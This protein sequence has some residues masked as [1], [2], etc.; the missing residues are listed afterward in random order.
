MNGWQLVPDQ[1]GAALV[2]ADEAVLA[3]G[4]ALETLTTTTIEPLQASAGF[5]GVVIGAYFGLLEE[6]AN[7]RL[8]DMMHRFQ[9]GLLGTSEATK[10][11]IAGDEEMAQSMVTATQTAAAT[12]DLTRFQGGG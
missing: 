10:A 4:T 8:T 7:G 11:F 5:D 12:G 9:A 1:I 3:V 2:G 6:Q